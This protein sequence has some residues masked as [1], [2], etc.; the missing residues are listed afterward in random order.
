MKAL[1]VEYLNIIVINFITLDIFQSI[2]KK[3]TLDRVSFICVENLIPR[4]ISFT[5]NKSVGLV[6]ILFLSTFPDY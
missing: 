1:E 4:D 2:R 5:G 3:G 6:D